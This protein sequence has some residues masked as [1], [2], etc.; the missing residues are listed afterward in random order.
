[1][2]FT[3]SMIAN[4]LKGEIVGDPNVEVSDISKIEEGRPGTLSF[5]SNP[6]YEKY[7]YITESS[8]VLVNRT[9]QPTSKVNATLVKVDDAYQALAALL[10]LYVQSKPVKE[11]IEKDCSI[12]SSA[13]IGQKVYIGS[14]SYIADNAKIGNNAKI[15]PQVYIGENVT[16][17]DNT[18]LYPGV[19]IYSDCKIGANCVIH[20]GAVIGADGF[21][22]APNSENNYKK[23]PQIGNV[24]IEDYVEIGANTAIDRATMGST[25]IR[26]GVK[27]DNLIQI[28]HN[29]EVGENTVMAAQAGIA[30]STKIGRDCMFGGQVGISGHITIAKGVKLGAKSGVNSSIKEENR[31]MIGAPVQDFSDWQKSFVLFR[32]FPKLA[33]QISELEKKVKELSEELKKK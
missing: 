15:Y 10:D 31:E 20:S 16:I 25:I 11:G 29:V 12:S 7:I 27:L 26:K 19:K 21:G 30:G 5:L 3:A 6:K 22:F 9:F 23:V 4:F 13:T 2:K 1:M 18:V 24:I 33:K 28:A 32:Q 8:I 14:Y 17:G